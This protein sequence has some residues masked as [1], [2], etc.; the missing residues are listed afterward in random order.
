MSGGHGAH[1]EGSNKGVALMIAILALILALSETG[2]K[3]SEHESHAAN[4]EA[5]N[6]WNFFQAKTIRRTTLQTAGEDAATRLPGI[7]DTAIKDATEKQVAK[8]KATADRYETEP[9]TQEGRR[10]LAARAKKAE[11]KRDL[12]NTRR[13][14]F[15]LASALLQIAIVLCSAMIITGIVWLVW[16][17]GG[18]GVIA[19]TFSVIALVAP[20]A[21][22]LF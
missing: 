17:A 2:A 15:E 12:A 13:H 5:T 11:E 18:L 10:E 1:V 16:I 7:G 3:N 20:N 14:H 8:W 21:I 19:V 9:E 6:L 22:H 4:I